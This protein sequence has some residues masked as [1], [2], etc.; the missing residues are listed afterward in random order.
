MEINSLPS[1]N[2]NLPD[3][4]SQLAAEDAALSSG[5]TRLGLVVGALLLAGVLSYA[6]VPKP[7]GGALASVTP[8][9]LLE[10]ASVTASRE[11]AAAAA[12]NDE[13]EPA[14]TAKA[15]VTLPA[16]AVAATMA[17]RPA[18]PAAAAVASQEAPAAIAPAPVTVAPVAAPVPAAVEPTRAPVGPI[19]LSGRILNE[20]GKPL[21]GATVLLKGSGKGTGTD[22]NGTYKLEAPAGD[23]TLI[24]GYGGYQDEETRV[25]GAQFQNVTL[26]PAPS[27][28]RRGR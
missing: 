9:F 24:F 22:A 12:R 15:T 13:A 3:Y 2:E 19:V 6:L 20:D 23:N 1:A 10:G 18:V 21:V 4:D 25:H 5:N 7:E 16:G 28:K 8:S 17:G 27:P 26:M 11:P 14:A